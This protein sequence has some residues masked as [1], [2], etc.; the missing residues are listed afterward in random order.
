MPDDVAETADESE[1]VA[2]E[3]VHLSA[4]AANEPSHADTEA[5]PKMRTAYVFNQMVC[6]SYKQSYL[7][8]VKVDLEFLWAVIWQTS[9]H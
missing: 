8:D 3:D 1:R 5:D 6:C 2:V 9:S 4:E 7:L